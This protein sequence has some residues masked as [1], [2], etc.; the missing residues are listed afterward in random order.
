MRRIF[1]STVGR[2]KNLEEASRVYSI[3]YDTG[4]ILASKSIPLANFDLS[5]INPRGGT[6][7]AR[8]LCYFNSRLWVAGWDGLFELDDETLDLER[9][10]WSTECKDIHQIYAGQFEITCVGTWDNSIY[11]FR[12]GKFSKVKDL[13]DIHPGVFQAHTP[14]RLHFNAM[15][16]RY[17][18]LNTIG[19]IADMKTGK[20]VVEDYDT[21]F[22]THDLVKLPTNEMVVNLSRLRKTVT[23]DMDTWKIK[24]TLVELPEVKQP[25]GTTLCMPGWM[26]GASYVG[27][28]NDILLLG[29]APASI[30]AI[31][32]V[33]SSI[34]VNQYR[35]IKV[36]DDT[37]ESVFDVIPHP[38]DWK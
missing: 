6:R 36:S 8:G 35:E 15:C 7:G 9:G 34:G 4:K 31:E 12:E 13:T 37:V 17:A 23:L 27:G 11:R 25:T 18:N 19:A 14:D 38:W 28:N 24:R 16:G 22:G 29:T 2:G 21:F 5:A 1:V 26:R 10:F 33:C 3:D 30:L 20:L 32:G